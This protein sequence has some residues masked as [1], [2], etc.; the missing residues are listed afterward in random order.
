MQV[1]YRKGFK[2]KDAGGVQGGAWWEM[3]P[4]DAAKTISNNI[5]YWEQNQRWRVSQLIRYAR[6]YGNTCSMRC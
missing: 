4:T 3:K 2:P 5:A 1:F 6:Q